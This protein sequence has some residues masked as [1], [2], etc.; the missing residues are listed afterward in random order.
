MSSS[1]A[2]LC[3]EGV[4]YARVVVVARGVAPGH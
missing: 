1:V 2:P 3:E 4:G